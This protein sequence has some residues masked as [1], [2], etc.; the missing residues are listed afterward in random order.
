MRQRSNLSTKQAGE[1][2]RHRGKRGSEERERE[3]R[4]SFPLSD[5]GRFE[6]RTWDAQ[7]RIS[8]TFNNTHQ[9]M[10]GINCQGDLM[11]MRWSLYCCR[12]FLSLGDVATHKTKQLPVRSLRRIGPFTH[13]GKK[14]K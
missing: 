3:E 14:T 1:G 7:A 8:V 2:E 10:L 12:F 13:D 5:A 4:S 11:Q 6:G 9:M